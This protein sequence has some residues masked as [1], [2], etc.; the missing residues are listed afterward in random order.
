MGKGTN[1]G[2]FSILLIGGV[3][4][5]LLFLF[6]TDFAIIRANWCV[7]TDDHCLREWVGALSGWAAALFAA[8]TI[9]YLYRQNEEQK[10]QTS[11]LLGDASPTIDAIQHLHRSAH[12]VIRI[13]NWN[14]RPIVVQTLR[15]DRVSSGFV[16]VGVTIFDKDTGEGLKPRSLNGVEID[17]PIA[18]HGWKNRAVGPCEVRIDIAAT[19]YAAPPIHWAGNSISVGILIAG[20]ERNKMTLSCPIAVAE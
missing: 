4:G 2:T 3:A 19:L 13:V 11:F 10:K 16:M 17:P 8:A 7:E 1:T 5:G 12:V 6:L 15:V 14:R 20:E 9:L 18:M